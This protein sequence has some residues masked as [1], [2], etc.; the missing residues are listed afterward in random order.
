M[1]APKKKHLN[2]NIEIVYLCNF[3]K[4][5]FSHKFFWT[6]NAFNWDNV[7]QNSVFLDWIT[8]LKTSNVSGI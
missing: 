8:L 3:T 2:G 4:S 5:L 7:S 6:A 1:N